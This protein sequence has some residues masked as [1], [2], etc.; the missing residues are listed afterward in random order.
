MFPFSDSW[1]GLRS[2]VRFQKVQL[3]WVD[4]KKYYPGRRSELKRILHQEIPPVFPL[5]IYRNVYLWIIIYYLFVVN[6]NKSS[7]FCRI[8]AHL[9]DSIERIE[10]IKCVSNVFLWNIWYP[11]YFV[12]IALEKL[13][14][15]FPIFIKST[16]F[17]IFKMYPFRAKVLYI[18]V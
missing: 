12:K 14:S 10:T 13:Y 8:F 1:L 18:S 9:P 11:R 17:E 4:Q 2:T 7:R 15:M 16:T 3:C 5:F 6:C